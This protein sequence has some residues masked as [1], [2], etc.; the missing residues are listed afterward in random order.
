V[1][2]I[3]NRVPRKSEIGMGRVLANIQGFSIFLVF[4]TI[5]LLVGTGIMAPLCCDWV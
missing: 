4:G 2:G 5:G 1:R 3:P